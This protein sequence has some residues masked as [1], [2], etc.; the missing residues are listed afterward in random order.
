VEVAFSFYMEVVVA[1]FTLILMSLTV[2]EFWVSR[3]TVGDPFGGDTTDGGAGGGGGATGNHHAGQMGFGSTIGNPG[4][5]DRPRANVS[6]YIQLKPG[7][8]LV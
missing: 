4:F 3:K 6:E 7:H 2:S 5:R 8:T 1:I